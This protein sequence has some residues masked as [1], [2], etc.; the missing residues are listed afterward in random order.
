MEPT[1]NNPI[2]RRLH[3]LGDQPIDPEIAAS[4]RNLMA[5]VPVASSRSRL[6]PLMVGSL[7]AGS[8]LGGVGLAAAG[9]GQVADSASDV[10][11]AVVV[12]VT[13]E[14]DDAKDAKDKDAKD[15]DSPAAKAAAQEAT[16]ARKAAK[17]ASRASGAHGVTRSTEDCPAN[18]TGTHGQYVSSVAKDPNSTEAKKQAAAESD[19]GKPVKSVKPAETG[20]TGDTGTQENSGK[21]GE[22]HGKPDASPEGGQSSARH[23][24]D[25]PSDQAVESVRAHRKA[26]AGK[27]AGRGPTT[28]TAVPAS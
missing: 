22:D 26:G 21:S 23:P 4:H 16:A 12:A 6:R 9:P 13:G 15:D 28:T 1:E 19:C 24:G 5:S 20:A 2:T 27:S 18:F 7:L 14:N 11:K 17:A 25:R 10:A 3:S 8:L